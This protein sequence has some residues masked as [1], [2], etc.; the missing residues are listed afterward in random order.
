MRR[1]WIWILP[2]ALA[3]NTFWL[4]SRSSLPVSLPHPLDWL[5]HA[6]EFAALAL[7]M[8]LAARATWRGA[9]TYRRHLAIFLL[10]SAYG[11]SDEVHQI[12]VAGR[13]A[14]VLDWAAD[15]AG[16]VAGL[17]LSCLPLLWR[18]WMA[19]L[20]WR[21]GRA[22]RPDPSRPLV[23]V[24]D[25][26]WGGELTGLGEATARLPEADWLFLGDIF[27]V[28][29]GI[30]G[31][32][33]PQQEAF[34]AW[35]DE[36]RRQGRWV[37]FW[38]GNR[39]Y[40]LDGLSDR[41][42]LMGEG[43]G[44]GLPGEALAWE[45]GDLINAADGRYRLWNLVSRSGAMWVVA[46]ALP[47]STARSLAA[48]LERSLRTT[49]RAYKLAFPREA[50]RAAAAAHPGQTFITGHFHTHE[51]EGNGTALPWAHDGSFM[52]W[53]NGSLKPLTPLAHP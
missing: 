12:F 20:G 10:A 35:V 5:A 21:R 11:L 13:D 23:L 48:R 1:T 19:A 6:T 37:G 43:I 27:D 3:I 22:E 14:S 40:F 29:V 41:F 17:A 47:R 7:A 15:S 24:A 32:E 44:G 42:D 33:S 30:P 28:W 4:S 53:E 46:R 25:P 2:L 39:E 52:L 16:A 26:H 49:N 36:R 8:E 51:V 38:L 50:F 9:P 45:H 18:R 34:L 31:M